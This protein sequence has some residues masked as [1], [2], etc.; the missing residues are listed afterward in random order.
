MKA[1]MEFIRGNY[2][3]ALLLLEEIMETNLPED[4]RVSI[5]EQISNISYNIGTALCRSKLMC[6]FLPFFKISCKACAK[7]CE[8]CPGKIEYQEQY[9]KKFIA[10][11]KILGKYKQNIVLDV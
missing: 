4:F 3:A 9:V 5:L 10:L 2:Q 7:L 6:D 8:Y 1:K 11:S